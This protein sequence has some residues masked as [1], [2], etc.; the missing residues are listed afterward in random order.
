MTKIY[1]L[2]TLSLFFLK[3]TEA[4]VITYKQPDCSIISHTYEVQV[5]DSHGKWQNTG[6]YHAD[7]AARFDSQRITKKTSFTYFDCSDS[8]SVRV[9]VNYTPVRGAR[10]RPSFL[11]IIPKIHGNI[12]EFSMKSSQY[13]SLEINGDIFENLQLFA[14]TIEKERPSPYDPNV[15]YLGPG[16]QNIGRMIVPSNKT[17]YIAGG[18]VVTGELIIDHVKNVNICGR[19]ILTQFPVQQ[20]SSATKQAAPQQSRNDQLLIQFS[21]NVKVSGIIEMPKG[22]SVMVGES[23]NVRINDFKAFSS[24]G[25]ADGIDIFCSKDVA[26][27]HIFMRNSDDCIAIYGHRWK[28]YGNTTDITIDN[29]TLWADVA[30]PL[31]IGT[32]GD[33]DHPD[34]LQNIRLRNM[35]VL[36]HHE[37]QLDYQGCIALNAGDS[38][39]IRNISFENVNIGDIRK[40]Q[41]FNLRVM[42]NRKYNTS[43]GAGMEDIVF[44]NV[45]YTG[46]H[47]NMSVI[48]GYD[49]QHAIK[50]LTFENLKINGTLI[51]DTMKGKPGFYKTG[52]MANIFIGEHVDGV[53][54]VIS[55]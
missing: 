4:E 42:F 9:K 43:P 22:Y 11:G 55:D 23:K 48:S 44:K 40:G 12:I 27:N 50:N 53:K 46:S 26:I 51:Y 16:I 14:N 31:L 38:N 15:I 13:I 35:T 21:E 41:L 33:S 6:V 49:E 32:H 1:L 25:N 7:V 36:D 3:C 5:R 54:F 52:D 17:V 10:V 29:A 34:T 19:G 8:V 30:H 28:Y 37:N 24:T 47:A 45:T 18:A 2:L 39:L 20:N